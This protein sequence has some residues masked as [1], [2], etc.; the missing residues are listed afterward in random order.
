MNSKSTLNSAPASQ[1]VQLGSFIDI[2]MSIGISGFSKP[3]G[4]DGG[5][6]LS[7][8]KGKYGGFQLIFRGTPD[9]DKSQFDPR[10]YVD[11]FSFGLGVGY[12]SPVQLTLPMKR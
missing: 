3:N 10:R 6:T 4:A 9:P 7:V 5:P 1:E 2:G 11:G 8:G 12:G